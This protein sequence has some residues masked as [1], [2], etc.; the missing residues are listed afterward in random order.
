[1]LF[2]KIVNKARMSLLTDSLNMVLEVLITANMQEK[3]AIQIRYEIKLSLFVDAIII[4][5]D[6]PEKF[7][8]SNK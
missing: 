3:K 6:N 1:M 2:P 8:R 4:Y 5:I 7:S